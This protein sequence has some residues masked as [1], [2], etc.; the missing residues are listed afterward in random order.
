MLWITILLIVY[1]IM[2]SKNSDFVQSEVNYFKYAELVKEAESNNNYKIENSI[3]AL[4]AYQFMPSTLNSLKEMFNLPEWKPKEGFLNNSN[5][6]DLYHKK[7]FES[8]MQ[9]L[10]S[11]G[12][13]NWLGIVVSGSKNPK[14]KNYVSPA[15]YYG[16]LAGAHLSGVGNVKRFFVD[17]TN[18]DDG[19]TS[20]SDYIA[21]FSD[22]GL[23]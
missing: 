21:F 16:F 10:K 7:L 17:G 18:K 19:H 2:K 20:V 6:Q 12:A 1:L 3:G 23:A 15:N 4:G 8:N 11:S 14:Y 5:L 22:K 13:D 9:G